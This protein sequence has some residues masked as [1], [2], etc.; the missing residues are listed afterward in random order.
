MG[1][2]E[3]TDEQLQFLLDA[4]K[5]EGWEPISPEREERH[6]LNIEELRRAHIKRMSEMFGVDR[7]LWVD[8]ARAWRKGRDGE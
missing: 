5:D 4:L 6:R 7:S 3:W 2:D 1:E 8:K